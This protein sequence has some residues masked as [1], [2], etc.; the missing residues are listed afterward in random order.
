MSIFPSN[1]GLGGE[2]AYRMSGVPIN[3]ITSGVARKRP[4]NKEGINA[5][6][7][8][9]LDVGQVLQHIGLRATRGLDGGP[10]ELVY[11][12]H[13]VQAIKELFEEG[14]RKGNT[15]P[16]IIYTSDT[17]EWFIEMAEVS[18]NLMRKEL[19]AA[20]R[21]AHTLLYAGLLKQS[22]KYATANEKKAENGA[23]GNAAQGKGRT[24]TSGDSASKK[25]VVD[26]VVRWAAPALLRQVTALRRK[27]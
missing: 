11:G 8:N 14:K 5:L 9:I 13:R 3:L 2:Y 7:Q 26:A 24:V 15:V 1:G 10:Y 20:E 6:K 12:A 16:A 19:T 27:Q 22:G 17:P 18:E 4:L 23:K 25:T 21:A